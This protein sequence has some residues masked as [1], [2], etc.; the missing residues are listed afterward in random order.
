VNL[1]LVGYGRMGK[2][3]ERVAQE[4][5]HRIAAIYTDV[6][7][8][9][10]DRVPADVEVFIDFSL[11]EAVPATV[12]EVARSGRPIVVGTTGWYEKLPEIREIV[13]E[14][15]IGLIY[16]PNFAL[17]VHLF[18][19]LVEWAARLYSRLGIYDC[20]IQEIHHAGKA[21]SPSGTALKLA[22]IVRS[23]WGGKSELLFDRPSGRIASHQLHV[24]SARCGFFP[25][26]HSLVID[27]PEDTIELRHRTR[28][29][30]VFARG[31]L[32]AA[33]W[34]RDR[35]GV[36]TAEDMLTDLLGQS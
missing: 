25:G 28:S 34:I 6:E 16:S 30:E 35:K 32:R 15:G 24:T 27:S 18:F 19:R 36:F 8:V 7:P 26:E 22:E 2:T 33:E 1:A 3:V 21:D 5:G 23:H 14:A 13:Q 29:R 17:G 11:P 4:G 9:R 31:A 10:A 20:C 12:R